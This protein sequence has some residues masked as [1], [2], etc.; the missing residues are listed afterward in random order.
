MI[1]KCGIKTDRAL[2]YAKL[3][4]AGRFIRNKLCPGITCTESMP[5][6]FEDLEDHAVTCNG[7]SIPLTNDVVEL[8]AGV[9][10]R[11]RFNVEQQRLFIQLSTETYVGLTVHEGRAR[12]TLF[13]EISHAYLHVRELLRLAELPH[14]EAALLRA[15]SHPNYY[16]S[17]WQANATSAAILMPAEGLAALEQ[18][19]GELTLENVVT[20][21]NVS[22]ISAEIRINIFN[23]RRAD[24]LAA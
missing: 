7:R 8:P 16:D 15:G 17:E 5:N 23:E 2:S 11:T 3:E 24:L 12:F 19:D 10:G 9:E 18:R 14:D 6:V 20:T 13:H 21:F 22:A 4:R 1:R